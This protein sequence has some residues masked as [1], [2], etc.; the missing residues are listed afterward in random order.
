[1]ER[2]GQRVVVIHGDEEEV[3][4]NLRFETGHGVEVNY[5]GRELL[6]ENKRGVCDVCVWVCVCGVCGG[7]RFYSYVLNFKLRGH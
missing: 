1:M 3:I 5:A 4:R 6:M 2:A 7:L